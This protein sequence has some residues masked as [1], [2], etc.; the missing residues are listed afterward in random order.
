MGRRIRWLS[1]VLVVCFAAVLAQLV[2]IQ[3]R[4]ATSLN[5]SPYNPRVSS[6]IFHNDR[7]LILAANGQV[8]A[9]SVAVT[10]ST[11]G[12]YDYRREYATGTLYAGIIGYASPYY[13]TRGLE[14]VYNSY[15]K[16]HTQKPQTL[17]QFLNPPGP[18]TDN[19]TLT[20]LP[21]LQALAKQ[22]LASIPDDNQDGSVTVLK[23][24]T[25]A[26]LA[27]YSNPTFTNNALA[28][29][30]TTKEKAA[31]DA[32]LT[33]DHEGYEPIQP[34]ATY[35]TPA[36]GSTFKVVTT[37][38]VYN[39][40]PTLAGFTFKV[41]G[42]TTKGA[43]KETTKVICNDAT[44]PTAANPCGGTI[45][46]MLPESCD[47]GY[48]MLGLAV[49]GASLYKQAELFGF[50][51]RPPIDLTSTIVSKANFP[52]PAELAPTGSLG[53]PGVAL[54]AFGQQTVTETGLQNAMVA[55]G[56]ADTGTVMT[57][58][59]M[60]EIRNQTG[61]LVESYKP[62]VYKKA[63]SAS[64][65][66]SVNKLMQLVVRTPKGTAHYV[67]FPSTWDIAVKTGTA[68]AGTSNQN[69]TDW[70]IGFAPAS[71]PVVAIAVEVPEQARTASG[72]TIAGPI[73]KA[74]MG[75]A[76]ADVAH[77]PAAPVTTI[78][79]TTTTTATTA[80]Q[81]GGPIA[82]VPTTTTPTTTPPTTTTTPTTTT[83]T[84]TP[85]P[86]AGTTSFVEHK[87]AADGPGSRSTASGASG[88]NGVAAAT[89]E[90]RP[91]VHEVAP[92]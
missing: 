18:T 8:L 90:R 17:Q 53:T 5:S 89:R 92:P 31:R 58:H 78:P 36:P 2:N 64:A 10:P 57:P 7:G 81:P 44:T 23:V 72:A 4:E 86:A 83:P 20:V 80:V 11:A 47:P 50:D 26:V 21:S 1:L 74:M 29:P 79:T 67:G 37:T 45:T 76:L 71:D 61:G 32:D 35:D 54:S 51:Q 73:M 16:T 28:T 9:K 3:L 43:I 12:G 88:R 49:G 62:S 38:A 22:E 59:L 66:K 30:T 85:A 55:E 82:T 33:P 91:A 52:T 77:A 34:F 87:A 15:L 25:G 19:V 84:V 41:A 65:A 56:I 13:G 27:M 60:A 39:L 68:Q 40:K 6:K 63:A 46:Q 14:Y 70:M 42:C 24:K 48:A 69:T 75:A